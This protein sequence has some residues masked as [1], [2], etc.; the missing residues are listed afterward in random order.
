MMMVIMMLK[1]MTTMV[2]MMKMLALVPAQVSLGECS[3]VTFFLLFF[4]SAHLGPKTTAFI[5]SPSSFSY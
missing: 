3:H 5:A 1:M 2:M 4:L